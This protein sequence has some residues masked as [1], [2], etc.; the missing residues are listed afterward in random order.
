[1][2]IA[3]ITANIGNFDQIKGIPRQT[4]D[5]DY[6][7]YFDNNL[8]FP[9]PNL[10]NRLKSKYVKIQTHRFLPNY[11]A[12]IWIDGRVEITA[13]V[14]CE[15]MIKGLGDN[16]V[17]IF[18][19]PERSTVNEEMGY[20]QE[21]FR[22]GN[23]YLLSRYGNQDMKAEDIFYQR[24][25]MGKYPLFACTIFARKNNEKVNAAFNE[26][27]RRCIE[28]SYF[29]QTMFTYAGYKHEL[30]VNT[31]DRKDFKNQFILNRHLK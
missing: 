23:H 19:H 13:D 2:K 28:F 4:I 1:M 12:Y 8:P 26:W 31:L 21:Q 18:D 14:F 27:W 15:E 25:G 16:D 22:L 3:L 7:C 20:M 30:T 29:D 5:V 24:E 11:D 6:Y 9:L 17:A 10:N